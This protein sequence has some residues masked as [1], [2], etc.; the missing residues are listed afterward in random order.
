MTRQNNKRASKTA[1]EKCTHLYDD[2]R[3]T[4][5]YKR[6]R[7]TVF[8]GRKKIEK[9]LERFQLTVHHLKNKLRLHNSLS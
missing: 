4:I 6:F 5:K 8:A 2:T 9:F 7:Q 1:L 3:G